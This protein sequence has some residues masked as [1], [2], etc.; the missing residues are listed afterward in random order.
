MRNNLSKNLL[1]F[2]LL[3]TGSIMYSQRTVRGVVSDS[4]GGL[5]GVTVQVKG[6]STGTQTDLDGNYSVTVSSDTS[7]L[8]FSYLGYKTQEI[9]VGSRST[10]N[11]TL[12]EDSTQLD[13]IVVIGYGK[14]TVKDA[15]GSVSSVTSENFNKGVVASPEQLIQGKTAGV[16][17][18][19]STGE[20]GAGI[21]FRIRGSNSIRSNN[22]PLFV[23]D[24]VPLSG[25]GTPSPSF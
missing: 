18:T 16:Q 3:L 11:V 14:T 17:I 2:V 1:L 20:P 9:T 5:P 24:G 13:E 7:V 21:A 25:G 4:E 6:T 8:V 22:N 19:Q 12:V 23:V 15:T 10:I